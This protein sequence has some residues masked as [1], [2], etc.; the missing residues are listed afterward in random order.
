M[1]AAEAK[2]VYWIAGWDIIANSAEE[3][4]S[5]A[6]SKHLDVSGGITKVQTYAEYL[7]TG[8]SQF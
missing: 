4:L 8:D 2:N 3:A 5:V 6:V 1:N 7:R